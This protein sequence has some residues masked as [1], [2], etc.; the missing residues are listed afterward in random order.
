[1]SN[2]MIR[3]HNV[4]TNEVIDREM[5]NEEY[6]LQQADYAAQIKTEMNAV[7]AKETARQSALD[8]LTALGLKEQFEALF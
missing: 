4:E 7:E 3:I 1:M 2:P 6:A 8:K 5:T